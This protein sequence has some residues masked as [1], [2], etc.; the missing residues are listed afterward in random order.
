MRRFAVLLAALTVVVVN[1]YRPAQAEFKGIS[2]QPYPGVLHVDVDASDV[3]HRIFRVAM[4]VPVHAGLL[5]LAYPQWIPGH[6]EPSGPIEKLAGLQIR[7]PQGQLLPWTRDPY[8]VYRFHVNVPDGV[9]SLR[10]SFQ[11]LSSQGGDQ[12]RI[13]MTPDLLNLQWSATVLYPANYAAAK[14]QV[15]PSVTLP[16]GW[17]Y[18]TALSTLQQDHD[19][20]RFQAI[21]LD[22]LVDSPLYAGR[23]YRQI[24]LATG[25]QP[26]NLN[27]FADQARFLNI[28]PDL[29]E[30]HRAIVA[31]MDRLY[32]VR[33][34]D[35][36]DFL[37]ALSDKL[38][39]IGLEHHRSSENRQLPGYFTEWDKNLIQRDLLTHEFNHSWNGKYRRGIDLTTP[40]FN[41]PMGDQLLWVYEGLTQFYGQVIAARSGLWNLQQA[42]DV[43]AMVAAAYDRG[44]PGLA[45]RNILDTTN[46][47]TIAQRRHLAYPNYQLSEDYYSGGEM[48]WLAV[49]GRIRQL[50]A[51]KRS[52]D[53]FARLFFGRENGKW[54]VSTYT[55]D[56]V[57]ATLQSIAANDWAQF[58]RQHL[59]GHQPLTDC[60]NETGWTLTYTDTPSAVFRAHDSLSQSANL[61]YSLGLVAKED[62]SLVDVIWDSPA[63][64]AGLSPGMHLVA[65]NNRQFSL[66]ELKSAVTEAKDQST[67]IALLVKNF[68]TYQTLLINYHGG[69][70][71]PS[72]VRRPRAPDHLSLLLAPKKSG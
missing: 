25:A 8:D 41:V 23:Y 69:L 43:F 37:L 1:A 53:D 50:T 64:Q 52:I 11:F 16:T 12:G 40:N 70:R 45:W 27:V 42:R 29:I 66:D 31:Q 57:V 55:F 68:D 56:D 14:I 9:D 18:A 15:E 28:K 46:D 72:L 26:V 62:G 49:D 33:H 17:R 54:Q 71:Y 3:A 13:M 21:D 4:A 10:V 7:D 67:P 24:Q 32:G 5:T 58:L 34:F 51:G 20:I 30:H 38:G 39:S 61:S 63:F 65:V 35:H 19:R 47:P 48:I 60:L 36:Y 6:H 22:N 44:R 59:D 2:E